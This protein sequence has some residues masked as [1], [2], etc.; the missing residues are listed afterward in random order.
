MNSLVQLLSKVSRGNAEAS[1]VDLFEVLELPTG[2]STLAKVQMVDK[3]CRD[4]GLQIVPPIDKGELS[5]ARRILFAQTEVVT[6]ELIRR[7][8]S[9]REAPDLELKSSL[10]YHHKRAA[11]QHNATKAELKSEDVLHS[12]LKTIAGFL[13]TNGGVLYIGADDQSQVIGLEYDFSCMTDDPAKQN[14]DNWELILRTYIRDRFKD[15]DSVNDYVGCYIMPV[16]GKLL[17]R[18]EVSPR[19]L[20]SF[21]KEKDGTALYRRQGNQTIRVSIDQVEE[22]LELR[23]PSF[24]L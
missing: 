24:E 10:L 7:D 5:S 17:A 12:S 21:L 18:L 1:L 9:R 4:Y 11:A 13:T 3:K 2:E 22:F 15:G 20:L 14:P 19:K 16:D 8:L 6:E 23:R